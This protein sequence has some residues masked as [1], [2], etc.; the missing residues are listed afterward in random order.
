MM[1]LVEKMKSR[2][3]GAVLAEMAIVSPLLLFLMLATAEVTRAFID[4]NT[5]TKAVRNGVRYVAANAFQGTTGVVWISA[6]LRAETQNLVVYGNAAGT[7]SPVLP[8]LVPGDVTITV[9]GVDDIQVTA[10]HT[11]SGLLGPVLSSFY[12]GPNFNMVHNL[13]AT[14]TMRAL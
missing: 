13:Q 7:G 1:R 14:V 9:L 3:R 5:L 6:A 11:I 2:Q 12:G 8:G 4:H 10:G